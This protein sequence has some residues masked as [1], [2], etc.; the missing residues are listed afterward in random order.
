M[1][2]YTNYDTFYILLYAS[3]CAYLLLCT[4]LLQKIEA[5]ISRLINTK[6]PYI[7]Y[8]SLISYISPSISI[9]SS[10]FSSLI[11]IRSATKQ[12]SFAEIC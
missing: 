7:M 1:L 9:I 5:A 8:N 12:A 6:K 11:M 10:A 3:L 2:S 4:L